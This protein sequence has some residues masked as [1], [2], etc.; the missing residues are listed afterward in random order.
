MSISKSLYTG[1]GTALLASTLS[2]QALAGASEALAACKSQIA[3]D[4]RMSQYSRVVQ[5]T[6]GIQRRGRFTNFDIKVNGKTEAGESTAW[7]V[8]CKARNSGKVETLEMVQVGGAA[9]SRVAQS[10]S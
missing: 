8:K 1:I 5:H 10:G 6:D 7:Q 9:E 3:D 2:S 4:A